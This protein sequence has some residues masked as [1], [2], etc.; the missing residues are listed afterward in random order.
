MSW[1]VDPS[2]ARSARISPITEQNLKPWPEKPRGDHDAVGLRVL[3]DDEV[4]VR[5]GLEEAG[6]ERDRRASTFGE[7]AL[8]EGAQR[9]L[10]FERRLA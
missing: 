9:R 2:I 3:V 8:G 7:V 6:L 1:R 5:R 4:L 10:V